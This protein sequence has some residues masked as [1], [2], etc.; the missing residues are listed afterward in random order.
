MCISLS[1][2]TDNVE[3]PPDMNPLENWLHKRLFE[4]FNQYISKRVEEK[5]K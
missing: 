1:N 2:G 4:A 5:N 3:E